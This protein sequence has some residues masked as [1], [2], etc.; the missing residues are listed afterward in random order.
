MKK[1][2]IKVPSSGFWSKLSVDVV[3]P[4]IILFLYTLVALFPIFMIII[5]SFKS[6]D[7]IFR[8][9]F[10]PPTAETFSLIGYEHGFFAR[11]FWH[12]FY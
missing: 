11:Q 8:A 7:A 5:N 4:Q 2:T 6:R 9:P 10:L 3:V 1:T 12:L